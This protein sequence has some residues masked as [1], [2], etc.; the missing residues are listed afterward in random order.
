[1]GALPDN[2]VH[3]RG[4]VK[5]DAEARTVRDGLPILDFTLVVPSGDTARD[6]YVDCVAY[7]DVVEDTEGFVE[8]G[9]EVTVEGR[10]GFR[11]WTDSYGNRKRGCI[12]VANSIECE[13]D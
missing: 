7:G 12:V 13:E 11:T 10:M 6:V 8:E 1:M 9:E 4:T 2:F 5:R 3:M